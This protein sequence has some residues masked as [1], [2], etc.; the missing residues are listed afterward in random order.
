M[1][2]QRVYFLKFKYLPDTTLSTPQSR[3]CFA[4]LGKCLEFQEL[5][6]VQRQSKWLLRS[7]SPK[8]S[9]LLLVSLLQQTVVDIIHH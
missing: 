9:S 5:N 8:W 6:G 3:F 4:V 7:L 1:N 2:V